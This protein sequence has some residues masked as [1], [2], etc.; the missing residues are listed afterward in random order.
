MQRRTFLAGLGA[1]LAAGTARAAPKGGLR[2]V[3]DGAFTLP[4]SML[5]E[6]VDPVRLRDAL[7]AAGL[8]TAEAMS[9]LNVTVL[10]RGDE[11]V[12]FDCGAGPN[13]MPGA[14]KLAGSLSA[15]GI[16]PERVKHVIF[17]H[18]HPDHLWGA[19]DDFDAPAFPDARYHIAAAELEFWTSKDVLDKLPEP[20]HAFA[21]GAQ[22]ILRALEPVLVR[23]KPEQE[24]VTGVAALDTPGHTPGHV[25]FEVRNGSQSTMVLGDAMTHPV[26]SFQYPDWRGGFDQVPDQAIATRRK[27]LD[28]LASE[29][30]PIIGYHLP[31]GGAGLAERTGAAY[32]FVPAG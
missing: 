30:M 3:S 23:F 4:V 25:S 18:A 22:R 8:P 9:P 21:A 14:G 11:V 16:A 31:R 32:R 6:G 19:L 7:A 29:H 20:R 26:I 10:E 17:T 5:S 13:F 15:A 28:R 1:V 24:I 2:T 27:L 12:L